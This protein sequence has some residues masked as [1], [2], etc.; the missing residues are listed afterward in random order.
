MD[1]KAYPLLSGIN[2]IEDFLRLPDS[3]LDALNRSLGRMRRVEEQK[4]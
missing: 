4:A 2:G 1:D 3:A